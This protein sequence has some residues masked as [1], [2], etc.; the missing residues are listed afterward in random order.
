MD[1]KKNR[2]IV[3]CPCGEHYSIPLHFRGKTLT[4]D[5]CGNV[6]MVPPEKPLKPPPPPRKRFR[7]KIRL[8]D[9][10]YGK[11]GKGK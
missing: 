9:Q 4:C 11:K 5:V 3:I 10:L 7:F 6:F 8:S 2:G 1:E